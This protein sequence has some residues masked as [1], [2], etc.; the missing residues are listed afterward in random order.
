MKT[1]NSQSNIIFLI[2][3]I[4]LMSLVATNSTAENTDSITSFIQETTSTPAMPFGYWNIIGPTGLCIS[5][6]NNNG[7]LVQQNC[8]NAADMMWT[9]QKHGSGYVIRAKNGR[10]IDNSR[11]GKNNGNGILGY[12]LNYTPAQIWAIEIVNG[13]HVHFRNLQRN[14]CLDDTAN[15]NVNE[16]YHLWDCSNGNQNQWFRLHH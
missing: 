5:S 7:R 2:T 1:M 12:S 15:H 11:Q 16:K 6:R 9:A 10:V 8:S 13:N 4:F 14:K 3:L